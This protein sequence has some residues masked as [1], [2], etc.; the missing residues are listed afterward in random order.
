[1]TI[2]KRTPNVRE[3]A[4]LIWGDYVSRD[5]MVMLANMAPMDDPDELEKEIYEEVMCGHL[6]VK[7]I[8]DAIAEYDSLWDGYLDWCDKHG[9][10]D[11]HTFVKRLVTLCDQFD[12]SDLIYDKDGVHIF[13]PDFWKL[14]EEV[15]VAPNGIQI[16]MREFDGL[17]T[18]SIGVGPF[19]ALK[20]EKPDENWVLVIAK[21]I[22]TIS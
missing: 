22:N 5:N 16:T 11:V 7:D 3:L 12:A 8:S 2:L 4:G 1:M 20:K 9:H 6:T 21:Y 15:N 14:V 18:K 13:N 17:T 10:W 19:T